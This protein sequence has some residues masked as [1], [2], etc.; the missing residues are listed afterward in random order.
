MGRPVAATAMADHSLEQPVSLV[1][2]PET[3]DAPLA[4][5]ALDPWPRV[6]GETA[7]AVDAPSPA[8]VMAGAGPPS[9]HAPKPALEGVD[10]GPFFAERRL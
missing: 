5:T 6:R 9:A 1:P 3:P 7:A 10:G 4:I 2:A 8:S